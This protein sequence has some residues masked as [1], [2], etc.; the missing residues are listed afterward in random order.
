[1]DLFA[2][3]VTSDQITFSYSG[4]AEQAYKRSVQA[5]V[6]EIN[7]DKLTEKIEAFDIEGAVEEVNVTE[8][9]FSPFEMVLAAAWMAGLVQTYKMLSLT[10]NLRK[11][12]KAMPR[13]DNEMQARYAD[14]VH[15]LIADLAKEQQGAV[16]AAILSGFSVKKRA[17]EIALDIAGRYDKTAGKR[18]GS[19]IGLSNPQTDLINKI[20]IALRQGDKEVLKSYLKLKT[21]D[22]RYDSWV[23]QVI[24]GGSLSPRQRDTILARLADRNLFIRARRLSEDVTRTILGTVQHEMINRQIRN[25]TITETALTKLWHTMEDKQV[26]FSHVSLNRKEVNFGDNFISGRGVSLAHPHDPG[27]PLSE[28][29]G[30][31]CWLEYRLNGKRI[32]RSGFKGF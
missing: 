10:K 19:L 20:D 5:L 9:S 15:P 6:D 18:V 32:G 29:S 17:R 31:R 12:V 13:Q 21:R 8:E 28:R 23:K 26:R 14:L 11:L 2:S 22:A 3:E 4:E 1:M 24:E 7:V 30:C 25:G 27:A 16:R